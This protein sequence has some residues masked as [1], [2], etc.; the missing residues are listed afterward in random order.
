[1]C[2]CALRH[3]P[4]Q[5]DPVKL[6]IERWEYVSPEEIAP[7]TEESGMINEFK[8][9][10]H[11]RNRFPLHYIVFRHPG[12]EPSAARGQAPPHPLP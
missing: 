1:M 10:W 9:M 5:L 3:P 4:V 8:L 2:P 12:L 7:F 11:M 6:E